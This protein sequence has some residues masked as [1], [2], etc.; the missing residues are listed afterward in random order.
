MN[1][2]YRL[3]CNYFKITIKKKKKKKKKK[4]QQLNGENYCIVDMIF[5]MLK[6]DV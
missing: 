5:T 4:Q 1:K 3:P 2:N 6:Y